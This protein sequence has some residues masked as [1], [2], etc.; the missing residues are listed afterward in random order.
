MMIY[1]FVASA[2]PVWLLLCPRDYLSSYLKIGTVAVLIIGVFFVNP[3][4]KFPAFSQFLHGG[5]IVPGSV[6]PFVFITIMCG[7]IS[8]FHALVSAAP[9]QR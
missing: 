2:L 4:L 1:G 5:P 8:G 7:A 3:T 6:F 9:R